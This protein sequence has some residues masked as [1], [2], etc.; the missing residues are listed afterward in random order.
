MYSLP[1][2][3]IEEVYF[4]DILLNNSPVLVKNTKIILDDNHLSDI[5]LFLKDP[6]TYFK[7]KSPENYLIYMK[8][9]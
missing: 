6:I 4:K 5:K 2:R 9:K 3:T 1:T 7:N 8:N